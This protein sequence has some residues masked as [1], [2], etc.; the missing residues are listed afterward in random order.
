M[1]LL[2]IAL[3]LGLPFLGSAAAQVNFSL[4]KS[5][6]AAGDS[7]VAT[8]SGRQNPTSTDWVGIYPRGITPG[9]Q[10]STDWLYVSGSR[11]AGAALESGSVTFASTPGTGEWTAFFLAQ[12]GYTVLGSFDFEVGGSGGGRS[13]GSFSL[14]RTRYLPGQAITASW[15][16]LTSPT[17]TD[18]VGIYPRN[19]AGVPDGNPASTIWQYTGGVGTGSVTFADPELPEGEWTAYLLLQDGY[20]FLATVEFEVAS[21]PLTAFGA[22]HAFLS[23]SPLVT[24]SWVLN[25][26]PEGVQTLTVSDGTT[27]IDVIGQDTLDVTP[28]GTTTYTLTLNG[29]ETATA[30]VFGDTASSPAFS[31]N[32]EA[33][34]AGSS[35]AVSWVGAAAAPDSWVGIY[36]EGETPGPVAAVA[37]NYLNG[38]KTPG[39]SVPDGTLQ[40]SLPEGDYFAILYGDGGYSQIEQGPVR[41]TVAGE[42][43]QPFEVRELSWDAGDFAVFWNSVPGWRYDVQVSSNLQS[44]DTVLEAYV[45]EGAQ[46]SAYILPGAEGRRFVRV[47]EHGR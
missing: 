14:D 38:S 12:D 40:F 24:L 21:P 23:D 1:N 4:D 33:L 2:R 35:L 5:T 42:A 27:A 19:L 45:A 29:S 41:F 31:L 47:L 6:Y 30:T 15:S 8:W 32:G 18:W 39:G 22:D 44:W 16:G 34:S 11:S 17:G 10:V 20:T 3:L 7:V 37:W 13:I 43:L 25:P 26:G 28:S 9:S 36:R 46:S